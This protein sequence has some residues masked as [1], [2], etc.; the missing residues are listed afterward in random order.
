VST[1][2]EDRDAELKGLVIQAFE[3]AHQKG[4]ASWEVMTLAV[5]KNR[6]LD[7]TDRNF[8][9][10]DFGA[11]KLPDLVANLDIVALEETG[12]GGSVRLLSPYR[13]EIAAKTVPG[14]PGRNN[15]SGPIRSDLWKAVLDYSN[16]EAWR[17]NQNLGIAEPIVEGQKRYGDL[18][19]PTISP[20][21]LKDWRRAFIDS[22]NEQ[23]TST[24]IAAWVDSDLSSDVLPRPLRSQWFGFLKENVIRLLTEWFSDHSISLPVDL[25][26]DRQRFRTRN[27][28]PDDLREW[29]ISCVKS[30]SPEELLTVQIPLAAIHRIM[31]RG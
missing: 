26:G 17:W 15:S 18:I 28:A 10:A 12:P 20:D 21:Q 14:P 23:N 8:R 4:N 22:K 25:V 9:E 16:A 11:P 3:R 31:N 30:M 7:I 29:I 13:E 27:Q 6:L 2:A 5:L 1:G 19:L 24:M